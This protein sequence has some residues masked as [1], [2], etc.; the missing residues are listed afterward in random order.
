MF[1]P[2]Q[3]AQSGRHLNDQVFR[4]QFNTA[5]AASK[6]DEID[7]CTPYLVREL[8]ILKPELVIGL[9]VDAKKVLRAERR[10]AHPA[11][12]EPLLAVSTAQAHRGD[13][14]GS[15]VRAA[16]V[17]LAAAAQRRPTRGSRTYR[18]R[19]RDHLVAG[20]TVELRRRRETAE[21]AATPRKSPGQVGSHDLAD[22]VARRKSCL[23]SNLKCAAVKHHIR[24]HCADAAAGYLD[25][26]VG[27]DPVAS[28]S[29]ACASVKQPIRDGHNRIEMGACGS[30]PSR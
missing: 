18:T 1:K 23:R 2:A 5:L 4:R 3:P 17:C 13:A 21:R 26:R 16:S 15:A 8:A 10:K 27:R 14:A 9:G 19:V 6:S 11:A 30:A 7:N 25:E 24:E 20:I 22:K 28:H 29:C 12:R